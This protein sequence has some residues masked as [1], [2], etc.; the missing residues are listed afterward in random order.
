M[1]YHAYMTRKIIFFAL[2]I[3]AI[4]AIA[5]FTKGYYVKNTVQPKNIDI[6]SFEECK[7][8]GYPI[9]ESYPEQCRTPDGRSFTRVTSDVIPSPITVS[10]TYTCLPK[11]DTGGPMTLECAFG[12]KSEKGYYALD[13]SALKS[14][15]YPALTG[16]ESI[17]VEG[18]LV[19]IEMISTDRWQVYQDL[20][21]I[22]S[23]EKLSRK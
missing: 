17:T 10:G 23:V 2:F 20:I 6:A 1:V 7:A 19:P 5:A 11:K 13:L 3:L 22:I 9:M 18:V 12:L 8:A 21:G 14:D 15:N 16:N 4:P